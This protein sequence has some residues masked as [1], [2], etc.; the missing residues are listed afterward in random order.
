MIAPLPKE[1]IEH[2][3]SRVLSVAVNRN[4]AD[5]VYAKLMREVEDVLYIPGVDIGKCHYAMAI[6]YDLQGNQ[7][8]ARELYESAIRYSPTE[9][10]YLV[11][12]ISSLSEMG[13]FDEAYEKLPGLIVKF[14]GDKRALTCAI[15]VS[16]RALQF[17]MAK[18]YHDMYEKIAI[19]DGAE[20]FS[21]YR[22]AFMNTVQ[23]VITQ[24]IPESHL[25]DLLRTAVDYLKSQSRDVLGTSI[26]AMQDGMLIYSLLI[27]DDFD[28]CAEKSFELGMAL[29]E[30]HEETYMEFLSITCR[31]VSAYTAEIL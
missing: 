16:Y 17:S 3:L 20:P 8:R 21:A 27:D 18:H 29:C 11:A 28:G 31:P 5:F 12:Y 19:N 23:Y 6:L 9:L 10:T 7:T 4:G 30:K 22:G 25:L 26:A 14:P 2:I 15:I 24:N 1:K 13:L